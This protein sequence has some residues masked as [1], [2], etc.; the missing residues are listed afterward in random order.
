MSGAPTRGP[1]AQRPRRPHHK[2]HRRAPDPTEPPDPDEPEEKRPK[3]NPIFL[4][5]S[6]REQRIVEV[7]CEDYD[8]RNRIKLTKTAQGWRSIPRT[9]V[10]PTIIPSTSGTSGTAAANSPRHRHHHRGH[11]HH[12]HHHH[13]RKSR[14]RTTTED[15]EVLRRRHLLLQPRVVLQQLRLP[16]VTA[17]S[18]DQEDPRREHMLGLLDATAA[19]PAIAAMA[20]DTPIADLPDSPNHPHDEPVQEV[21]SAPLPSPSPSAE[22]ND[23]Q[24]RR[25]PARSQSED[26]RMEKSGDTSWSRSS[27]GS[28]SRILNA[29]RNTPGLSVSIAGSPASSDKTGNLPSPGSP[30]HR[31][32]GRP[33]PGLLVAM[34]V[35]NGE[36]KPPH[37]VPILMSGLSISIPSYRYRPRSR[38]TT[39][40]VRKLDPDSPCA[41]YNPKVEPPE[42]FDDSRSQGT[43]VQASPQPSGIPCSPAAGGRP[44]SAYLERLLPS[45]P[46][47]VSCS[48][49]ARN[50]LTL[51]GILASPS[52]HHRQTS[53]SHPHLQTET[54]NNNNN[55]E[56]GPASLELD[57]PGDPASELREL[58]R[59]SGHL[60]PD[61]LLVPRDLLPALAAAPANEIPRLLASRPELRLPQA[62]T[63][64]ELLRD[65]DLLVIS[66]AHLQHVLDY[67]E[68]PV[69]ADRRDDQARPKLTCK[70]IGTLMPAPIDL[71][72]NRPRH[73]TNGGSY[74]LLRV[75][76]TGLLKQESEVTSTAASPEDS[77]FWHPLF[78]SQKRHLHHLHQHH[79]HYEQPQQQQ[80]QQQRQVYIQQAQNQQQQHQ[81]PMQQQQQQQQQQPQPQ[82]QQQNH[83]SWHRATIAS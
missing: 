51:K 5:A 32:P 66:L 44:A 43:V 11:R 23:S 18:A 80:Q 14:E 29:L 19:S 13:R 40:C 74:P 15:E 42:D 9:T 46:C 34:P 82:P 30:G 24:H 38:G 62:L 17:A 78:S 45:P 31:K 10:I 59:V 21:V 63:R 60:I 27:L 69:P 36:G 12:H 77:Q 35:G 54:N 16:Q 72:A 48:E 50:D 28:P 26:P 25:R 33:P 76:T 73:T 39:P 6:Q 2:R 47:S 67:G 55:N 56:Y 83:G 1:T 75:R 7:R 79:Y 68:G 20:A 53:T 4:W 61:P 52:Q 70:P 37:N 65:P 49:D 41:G 71:S 57:S 8:K 3:V 81:Q 58:L 22:T 64:P